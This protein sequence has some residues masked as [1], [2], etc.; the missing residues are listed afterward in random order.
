MNLCCT[1]V[2]WQEGPQ[3]HSNRD[4]EVER[5]LEVVLSSGRCHGSL[6]SQPTC[7]GC[8]VYG[9]KERYGLKE[10]DPPAEKEEQRA[11]EDLSNLHQTQNCTAQI[12][13]WV[14]C[15]LW[16]V[17]LLWHTASPSERPW[18]LETLWQGGL[19]SWVTQGRACS[20]AQVGSGSTAGCKFI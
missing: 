7:L 15:L 14:S 8:T 11:P 5:D 10:Q 19:V 9:L 20:P 17:C 13:P 12:L 16:G 2:P 3:K 18:N 4:E 1:W 6:V